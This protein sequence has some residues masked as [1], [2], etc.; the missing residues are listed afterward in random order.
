VRKSTGERA[1]AGERCREGGGRGLRGEGDGSHRLVVRNEADA[2]LRVL[3]GRAP[4]KAQGVE[5]ALVLLLAREPL[6][7]GVVQFDVVGED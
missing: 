4:Q 6:A 3:H 2:D 1:D 7:R 5:D